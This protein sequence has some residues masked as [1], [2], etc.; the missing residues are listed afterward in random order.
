VGFYKY[1][2]E[3][4]L[5]DRSPAAHVRRPRVDYESVAVAL[6]RNELGALLVAA[7]L[8]PPLLLWSQAGQR[9]WSVSAASQASLRQFTIGLLDL[10]GV[11]GRCGPTTRTASA[12]SAKLAVCCASQTAAA[13]AS[14]LE[15]PDAGRDH[16]NH[17]PQPQP[18]REPPIWQGIWSKWQLRMPLP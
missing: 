12:C 9:D 8:G 15:K 7:G 16:K 14:Y 13:K 17:T 10:S 5:L 2:V 18:E 4:E 6:D 11:G 3:E 1:A